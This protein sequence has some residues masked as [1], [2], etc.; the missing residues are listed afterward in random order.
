[1]SSIIAGLMRSTREGYKTVVG[2]AQ[3]RRFSGGARG[4][5]KP[6]L[7][8]KWFV[9]FFFFFFFNYSS[10]FIRQLLI[11]NTEIE[12]SK[13]TSE[14]D[15]Q[16]RRNKLILREK[17]ND[18]YLSNWF[19]HSG[20]PRPGSP[21][22]YITRCITLRHR[23]GT[24]PA[25]NPSDDPTTSF[26]GT[27]TFVRRT[28]PR[29]AFRVFVKHTIAMSNFNCAPALCTY[30]ERHVITIIVTSAP[31]CL[32]GRFPRPRRR[33]VLARSRSLFVC[34]RSNHA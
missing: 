28:T 4:P 9:S 32:F 25:S 10:Y 20:F 5:L 3:R 31:R 24:R 13:R 7:K 21:N 16:K 23:E 33:R 19:L 22:S 11:T 18:F 27:R 1:L 12:L 26:D 6:K 2:C 17:R 8:S 14:S 34:T 29:V 30:T 15:A